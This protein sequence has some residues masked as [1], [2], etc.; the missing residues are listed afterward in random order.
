MPHQSNKVEENTQGYRRGYYEGYLAGVRAALGL[1]KGDPI[2]QEF[3]REAINLH[4][5][6]IANRDGASMIEPAPPS[7]LPPL[8]PGA[9]QRRHLP[10]ALDQP[11]HWTDKYD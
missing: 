7:G 8:E 4:T 3:S 2:P 1:E 11:P 5:W 9:T 6:A 10:E